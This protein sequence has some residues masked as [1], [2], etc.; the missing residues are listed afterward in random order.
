MVAE[1]DVVLTM[2]EGHLVRVA[3]L[4]GEGRVDLLTRFAE[5]GDSGVPDPFGGDDAV[6]RE[7]YRVLEALVSRAL[8][9]LANV[10]DP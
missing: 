3:A 10:V 2:S 8:D 1:A 6:Y 4:G 9:R 7:T 5:A